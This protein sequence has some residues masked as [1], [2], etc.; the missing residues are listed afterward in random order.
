MSEVGLVLVK[1]MVD[2]RASHTA[3]L[4][5]TNLFVNI[6]NAVQS[7]ENSVNFHFDTRVVFMTL[8]FLWMKKDQNLEMLGVVHLLIS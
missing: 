4:L 7:V 5:E 1:E 2:N 3:L 6:P 8:A